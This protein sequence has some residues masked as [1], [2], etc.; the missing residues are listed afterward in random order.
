MTID[1]YK[2]LGAISALIISGAVLSLGACSSN[3]EFAYSGGSV[4]PQ[5]G[6]EHS[7]QRRPAEAPDAPIANEVC[8]TQVNRPSNRYDQVT[9][10]PAEACEDDN[11]E[12]W[13]ETG[14]DHRADEPDVSMPDESLQ[15]V[16]P[17]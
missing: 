15:E 3:T 9:E 16:E 1:P 8:R 14:Q 7:H 10:Q 6:V 13:R 11:G 12:A 5:Y 4:P 2:G 17:E